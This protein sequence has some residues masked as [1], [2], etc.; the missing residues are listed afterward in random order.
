MNVNNE[1]MNICLN[2]HSSDYFFDHIKGK[3]K[4]AMELVKVQSV[5]REDVVLLKIVI[6][7]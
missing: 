5:F 1:V 4:Q 2:K 6:V 3:T 7:V